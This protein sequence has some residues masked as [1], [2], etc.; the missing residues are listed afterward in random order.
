MLWEMH[1]LVKS[2]FWFCFVSFPFNYD[3]GLYSSKSVL[4]YY[5]SIS[6]LFLNGT[7]WHLY[8]QSQQRG[9]RLNARGEWIVTFFESVLLKQGR[10]MLEKQGL[11]CGMEELVM[12]NPLPQRQ[13]GDVTVHGPLP[14]SSST[15]NSPRVLIHSSLHEQWTSS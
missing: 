10:D 3:F 8:W 11:W 1:F 4:H 15:A 5:H 12:P 7:N 6:G 13:A 2:D 14:A 9:Q